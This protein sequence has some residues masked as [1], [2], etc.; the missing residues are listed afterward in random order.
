MEQKSVILIHA[1]NIPNAVQLAHVFLEAWRYFAEF[2]Q[3][4]PPLPDD[5]AK[6]AGCDFLITE[7]ESDDGTRIGKVTLTQDGEVRYD[8]DWVISSART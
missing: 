3:P 7:T 8:R 5:M 1:E 6:Y 2:E 4:L